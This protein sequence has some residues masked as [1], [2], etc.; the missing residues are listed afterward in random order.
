MADIAT[1]ATTGGQG[2]TP[3]GNTGTPPTGGGSGGGAAAPW[4][5]TVPDDIKGF[6]E[7][8][9][10]DGVP[11]V[12]DSYRN[13]EK[14]MGVPKERLLR[15]PDKADSPEWN[16]VYNRLGRPEK[17]DGYGLKPVENDPRSADFVKW[18]GDQFHKLGLTKTQGESLVGQWSE[19][20]NQIRTQA[21]EQS[22]GE[23][24][25]QLASLKQEW[26]NAFQ[27]KVAR[28]GQ[29]L[30]TIGV[31]KNQA[32]LLEIAFGVDGAAKMVDNIITKFGIQLGE[33]NFRTGGGNNSFGGSMTPTLA[34]QK[35]AELLSTP[36]WKAKYLD[37]S[38]QH[39]QEML[40]LEESI[41]AGKS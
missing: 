10:W 14:F 12:V 30:E 17:A 36:E 9:G 27:E 28:N 35:K 16:D 39:I 23:S 11:T 21:N 8:K 6:I 4:F 20:Q 26:G 22:A 5:G 37:G 29:F 34:A 15:L 18:A 13:L 40:R 33:H 24:H 31:D 3:P 41:L 7:S 25:Q 19:Y 32:M 2:G 1:P 38:Q